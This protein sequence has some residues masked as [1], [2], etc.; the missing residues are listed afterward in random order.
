MH[1]CSPIGR[2]RL[3]LSDIEDMVS[4]HINV[5]LENPVFTYD[6]DTFLWFVD[7]TK[8]GQGKKKVALEAV[9]AT[10]SQIATCFDLTNFASKQGMHNLLEA[11]SR[12]TEKFYTNRYRPD[13]R[14]MLIPTFSSIGEPLPKDYC[15][16]EV[17][18]FTAKKLVLNR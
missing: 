18:A 1:Y 11:F 15:V 10:I 8:V 6:P 14:K 16:E 3:W 7:F 13:D 12:A 4:A 5:G 2:R 17:R 9:V